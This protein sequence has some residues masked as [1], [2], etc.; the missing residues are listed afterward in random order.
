MTEWKIHRE[1]LT[2][3]PDFGMFAT[4]ATADTDDD[5]GWFLQFS[6]FIIDACVCVYAEEKESEFQMNET[7]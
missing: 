7:S 1:H 6:L 3:C 5:N 4:A 2:K